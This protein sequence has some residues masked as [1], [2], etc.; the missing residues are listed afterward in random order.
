MADEPANINTNAGNQPP[1][2]DPPKEVIPAG[3]EQPTILETKVEPTAEPKVEPKVEPKPGEEPKP[4]EPPSPPEKYDLKLPEN[5]PLDKSV[6]DRIA[7]EAKKHGLSQEHAQSLLERENYAVSS[8]MNAQQEHLKAQA[9]AWVE[10]V[11]S[12]TDIGGD[13]FQANT[14]LAKRVVSRFGTE[15]FAKT[16]NETGLGNHPELVRT[17]VK[18]G[19]AMSEDQLVL[20]G[21]QNA[22]VKKSIEDT[23]Y[24]NTTV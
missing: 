6:V 17:F 9:N 20:P 8:H 18:I 21:S 16:L 4:V 13:N 22:P 19:K 2:G 7:A 1:V 23:L 14:E 15:A 11:K 12:D 3:G 10:E 24:D 5:S